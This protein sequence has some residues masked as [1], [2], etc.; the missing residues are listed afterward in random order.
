MELDGIQ[1]DLDENAKK[2]EEIC[3]TEYMCTIY[4]GCR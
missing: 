1:T 3:T 4:R 2:I